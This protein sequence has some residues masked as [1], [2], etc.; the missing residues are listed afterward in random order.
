MH[1]EFL[2]E[3]SSLESALTQLLPKILPSTVTFKIHAFRGK[4][5][6][7]CKLPN[8]L[9]G[10]QAWLPPD[11]KIV[12]L[13]DEDREDC[14][15]LKKQLEN[16]AILAGLITKSSCQKN[17][18]FQVLN[19]IVVEELEAWFF[20]DVEAIC[21]AYPKVSANL[22]NQ[23]PYRDP[24]AIKGGTWEALERVLRRAGYHQGGLEKYKASSEIS[25]YM[26]PESNRSKSFQVFCQGLLETIDS[27][28]V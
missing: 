20:G 18:S 8:R 27:S 25:K 3:E 26:N 23:Q 7:I 24:D 1:F 13:I 9:K 2:V 11:W 15:K 16:I 5:D 17:K 28:Q 22:A 10:Y 6:L 4:D 19:R 14:L 21:Q 12:I